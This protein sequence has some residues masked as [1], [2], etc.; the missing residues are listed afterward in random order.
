MNAHR[1][2]SLSNRH[3]SLRVETLERRELFA[4]DL[5]QGYIPSNSNHDS[6]SGYVSQARSSDSSGVRNTELKAEIFNAAGANAKFEIEAGKLEIKIERALPRTSYE[7]SLGGT[8]LATLT[9]DSRGRATLKTSAAVVAATAVAGDVINVSGI[10]SGSLLRHGGSS[11]TDPT[12]ASTKLK[13]SLN[14]LG[15]G[16]AEFETKGAKQKFEVEVRG[17]SANT[18]YVVTVD[19]IVVGQIQTDRKGKGELKFDTTKNRPFPVGFPT[20][21]SGSTVRV[22]DATSGAFAVSTNSR[23]K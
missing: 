18:T 11:N 23:H 5:Y 6:D 21:N 3:R 15:T 16:K 10:G 14:G 20:I 13:A 4:G 22:G 2:S 7:V 9:T 12:L 1:K 19:G 8:V 17:L